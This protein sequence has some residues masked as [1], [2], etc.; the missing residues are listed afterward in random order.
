MTK[1]SSIVTVNA[2]RQLNNSLHRSSEGNRKHVRMKSFAECLL[3]ESS[4]V[5]FV[6]STSLSSR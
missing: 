1:N 2:S 4:T 5:V 3:A 6:E